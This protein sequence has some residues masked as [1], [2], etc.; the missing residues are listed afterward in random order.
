MEIGMEPES[1]L[2]TSRYPAPGEVR[3]VENDRRGVSGIS[4]VSAHPWDE[5]LTG[6]ENELAMAAAQAMAAGKYDGMSPLVIYGPSGV[7]KS[8]LLAGLVTE[9]LQRQRSSSV[10]HL[11]A[12]A[13]VNACFEAATDSGGLGWPAFHSQFRS[14]DLFV[15]EDIEGLKRVPWARDELAYTL[16][17]LETSGAAVAVSAQSLPATWPGETWP[18]RLVNRL[19]GGLAA[20]ITPPELTSRRRYI[21]QHIRQYGVPLEADTV[22]ALAEAGDGY[23][24]LDGWISRLV[25]E[26]R[27]GQEQGGRG[28]G[29]S[30]PGARQYTP[31]GTLDPQTVATSLV[32]EMLLAKPQLTINVVAQDVAN[33][34]G[35]PLNVLRGPS[36]QASVVAA[37]HI[38]MHLA[39]TLTRCSF[40]GIGTYFGGRDPAS[41]RYACRM[42]TV[43]LDS[44]PT[45]SAMLAPLSQG[46]QRTLCHIGT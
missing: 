29:Q 45:L 25:L 35:V 42:A 9:W 14:V 12:R 43:R 7:G 13:F 38:A 28:A 1:N 4:L 36:R 18:R 22:E 44:D 27:L 40:A 3:G 37:R 46:W 16:D 31:R 19:T 15:L 10:A 26:S 8:R 41:V 39:R 24:T 30:I 21:L 34:L 20:R 32:E 17:A 33:R 2:C 11:D 5:Y 23:R 6:P